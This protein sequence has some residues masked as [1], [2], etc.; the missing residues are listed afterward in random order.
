MLVY[1]IELNNG[2][3][4]P[5]FPSRDAAVPAMVTCAMHRQDTCMVIDD[6]FWVS[7]DSD[8]GF[9]V[10]SVMDVGC[11]VSSDSNGGCVASTVTMGLWAAR[12]KDYG[13]WGYLPFPLSILS[14]SYSQQYVNGI[15]QQAMHFYM[16]K[17]YIH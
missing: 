10:S 4:T 8:D 15:E 6:G 16:Y 13:F 3:H 2:F 1:N 17:A 11:S 14:I 7:S 5:L 9:G 12:V